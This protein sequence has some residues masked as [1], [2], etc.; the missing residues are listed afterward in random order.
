MLA[1]LFLITPSTQSIEAWG[2][3]FFE[4]ICFSIA[5][6]W[7]AFKNKRIAIHSDSFILLVPVSFYICIVLTGHYNSNLFLSTAPPVLFL[8][9]FVWTVVLEN[10]SR[11]QIKNITVATCGVFGGVCFLFLLANKPFILFLEAIEV[12]KEQK[13]FYSSLII[14]KFGGF[15]QPNNFA[16]FAAAISLFTFAVFRR[17][18]R[19]Q[20]LL[21]G[22]IIIM[23][24]FAIFDSGSKVGA[25]GLVVGAGLYLAITKNRSSCLVNLVLPCLLG[26][27]LA[28]TDVRAS[29]FD[30]PESRSIVDR[31]LQIQDSSFQTRINLLQ[32]SLQLWLQKPLFGHGLDSFSRLYHETP[33]SLSSEN[34]SHPH[35]V[36]ADLAVELGA[37]GLILV[38]GSSAVWVLKRVRSGDSLEI[39]L[40]STPLILHS[41][42][43]FPQ[44]ASLLHWALFGLIFAK[45]KHHNRINHVNPKYQPYVLNRVFII[46]VSCICLTVS[47]YMSLALYLVTK[48][49]LYFEQLH[50]AKIVVLDAG[51]QYGS[52]PYVSHKTDRLVAEKALTLAVEQNNPALAKIFIDRYSNLLNYW[53]YIDGF[54]LE[55]KANSLLPAIKAEAN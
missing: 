43:G 4:G 37:I 40:A 31:N 41:F 12:G 48:Q 7:I 16:S 53:G 22:L 1:V 6:I 3:T 25:L 35:N 39:A 10:L 49:N 2:K 27:I 30:S 15:G 17:K 51:S 29:M 5:L 28:T 45:C 50:P 33:E 11:S 14:H 20:H 9:F 13:I 46:A 26:F 24:S 34:W 42:T 47:A 36:I 38:L 18:T 8:G 23:C 54:A 21:S 19:K 55:K 44:E 32:I 52:L